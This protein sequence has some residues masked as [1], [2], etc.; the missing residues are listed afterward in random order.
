MTGELLLGEGVSVASK[1]RAYTNTVALSLLDEVCLSTDGT[2][3]ILFVEDPF[4]T[5]TQLFS[6]LI[7]LAG[8]VIWSTPSIELINERLA[9][10]RTVMHTIGGGGG[11]KLYIIMVD[12][13]TTALSIVIFRVAETSV[14]FNLYRTHLPRFDRWAITIDMIV[15]S[16]VCI[17]CVIRCRQGL[18][19]I[20]K[21]NKNPKYERSPPKIPEYLDGV[22]RLFYRV[23]KLCGTGNDADGIMART[24]YEHVIVVCFITS[25]PRTLGQQF[26]FCTTTGAGIFMSWSGGVQ[27]PPTI[28]A[29]C[30]AGDTGGSIWPAATIRR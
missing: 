5:K 21:K 4:N 22:V 16:I 25:M 12:F 19:G 30:S 13:V 15:S 17:V 23:C 10:P 9:T 27:M 7:M 18:D 6:M 26:Y 11:G 20:E 24:V 29:S 14:H 1:R 2:S 3:Y 8:V 28:Q